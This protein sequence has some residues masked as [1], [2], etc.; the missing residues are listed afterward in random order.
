MALHRTFWLVWTP[1]G[2]PPM[3]KHATQEAATAEAQRLARNYTNQCYYVLETMSVS[4][5]E[6]VITEDCHPDVEENLPF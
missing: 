1:N 3:F 2:Y 5:K 6:D 4:R